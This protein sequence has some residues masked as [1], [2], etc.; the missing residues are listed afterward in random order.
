MVDIYITL[1]APARPDIG[2][3]IAGKGQAGEADYN[4]QK[5]YNMTD[6]SLELDTTNRPDMEPWMST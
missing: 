5:A 2:R 1:N 3:G 4:C 6:S